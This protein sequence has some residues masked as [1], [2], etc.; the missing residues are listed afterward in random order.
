[1]KIDT[2]LFDLDGTLIDTTELIIASFTHTLEHYFPGQYTREQMIQYIGPPLVDTFTEI[3]KERAEEMLKRYIE[4]NHTYH[5]EL[6]KEYDGVYETVKALHEARFKLGIVTSKMR[7]GTML[8]LRLTKLEP[9]FQTIITVDDVTNGKPHPEPLMKAMEQLGASP[10]T[11]LMVGDSDHDI[12]GG[13]NAGTKT[14]GVCWTI[15]G[16]DYLRSFE[17]DYMLKNMRDLLQ[18]VGV[19]KN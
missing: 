16:E 12:L 19:E 4:H 3:D 8:G 5:D 9:F 17:P 13:K 18:I 15:K 11:T 14:A 6:V 1:M 2:I 10:E 7:E